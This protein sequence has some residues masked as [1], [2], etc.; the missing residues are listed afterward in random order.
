[1]GIDI[2][3]WPN[4]KRFQGTV[5]ARPHVLAALKAEGLIQ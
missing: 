5:G 1:V 3:Q 2:D 4:L